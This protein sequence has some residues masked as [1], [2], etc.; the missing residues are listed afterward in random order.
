MRRVGLFLAV[1]IAFMGA[2]VSPAAA[3]PD[4]HATG[5]GWVSFAGFPPKLVH[6]DISA[7]DRAGGDFGQVGFSI[8]EPFT[9]FTARVDLDCV[10]IFPFAPFR[11]VAWVAGVVTNADPQ[12]NPYLIT[13]GTRME[14]YLVDNGTPSG[15]RPVDLWDFFIEFAPCDALPFAGYNPNVTY[16]NINIATG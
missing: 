2:A 4:I 1:V 3:G 7:H 16:G 15:G 13:P 12:P 14:F 11:G 6:F 9:P 8:N 5:G 10:N